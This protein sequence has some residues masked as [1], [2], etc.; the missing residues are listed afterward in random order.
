MA[1]KATD[2]QV[3]DHAAVAV[4]DN[5]RDPF[6]GFDIMELN[7]CNAQETPTGRMRLFRALAHEA[8]EEREADT[9]SSSTRCPPRTGC[10]I[11]I[12]NGSWGQSNVH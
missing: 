2:L 8:V 9:G 1:N 4:K 3:S 5:D 12:I 7:V 11:I 6:P 10:C